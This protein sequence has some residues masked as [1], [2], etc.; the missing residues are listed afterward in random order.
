MCAGIAGIAP[1]RTIS[2]IISAEIR[3]GNENFA[4]VG[5][6]AG[7]EPLFAGARGSEQA[8]QV[9]VGAGN[10]AQG[11]VPGNWNARLDLM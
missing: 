2:A 1:K 8:G 6:N 4:R 9:G 3:Q 5:D 11:Q 10:Q 7:L